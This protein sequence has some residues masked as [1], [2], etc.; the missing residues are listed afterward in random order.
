[1]FGMSDARRT[2]TGH[3]AGLMRAADLNDVGALIRRWIES[4]NAGNPLEPSR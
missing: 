3:F 4:F 1:V 2:A